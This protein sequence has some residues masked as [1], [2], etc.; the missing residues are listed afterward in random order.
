MTKK[1]KCSNDCTVNIGTNK[2]K[3]GHLF[4][5]KILRKFDNNEM[6]IFS[7]E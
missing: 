2:T 5:C 4:V 3:C 6:S 7:K 1:I